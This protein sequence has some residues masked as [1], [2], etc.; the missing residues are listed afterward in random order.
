MGG[1]SPKPSGAVRALLRWLSPHRGRVAASVVLGACASVLEV[2]SIGLVAPL[3]L[4]GEDGLGGLGPFSRVLPLIDGLSPSGRRAVLLLLI[5]GGMA[6]RGIC[7]WAAAALRESVGSEVHAECR[8]RVFDRL[9][10]APLSWFRS[11]TVGEHQALLLHESER[12]A[13]AAKGL[14]QLAVASIMAASFGALLLYLAPLLTVAALALL[15]LFGLLLRLLRRPIERYADRMRLEAKAV[16]GGIHETLSGLHVLRLLGR[17][18]D[19]LARFE[20]PNR[21]FLRAQRRQRRALEAIL[22]VSELAGALVLVGILWLGTTVLPVRG[23]DPS[24]VLLL[25]YAFLFYRLLPRYLAVVTARAGMAANLSS[26]PAVEAF[27]ADEATAPLPDGSREPPSRS[28][29][30][31]FEGV[32]FRY[33]PEAPWILD[34]LDLVLEP[35]TTTALV[36]PSGAGKSTVVDLLLG[37]RRPTEG[38]VTVD[39]IDL[40]ELSGDAWRRR[41][42]VVPQDPMLFHRSVAENLRLAAPDAT[43][44]RIAAA[45][46]VAAAGFVSDLPRGLETSLGDRGVRLSGG[47]RQR[48]SI[49]RALL[50]DPTLL[51]FDEA[52]SQLDAENERAVSTAIARASRDRTALVIAHRL[53]TV[54]S[55]D[56]IVLLDG[57]RAVETGSHADLMARGGRYARLVRLGADDLE[58]ARAG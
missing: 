37:L 52:T 8:R 30:V 27:L 17:T 6:M 40:A 5:L 50:A 16:A 35:G 11:K 45:L 23:T 42:G 31:A 14:V 15:A 22:P 56:R 34:G 36:G 9:S 21:A 54:R 48:L 53:S 32:R 12:L 3:L 24:P 58:A 41:V 26:V 38:R 49:A 13:Q 57:G 47:E 55:A 43:E 18:D 29:R 20:G 2:A 28:P 7:W 39:G 10:R 4:A 51:V 25:P 46:E 1:P 44:E 33:A 19:A